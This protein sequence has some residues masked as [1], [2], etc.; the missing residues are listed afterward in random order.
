MTLAWSG[1][2]CANREKG[3]PL[4]TVLSCG[5]FW[6]QD[7]NK[8]PFQPLHAELRLLLQGYVKQLQ[9]SPRL[10]SYRRVH[11][12]CAYC[13]ALRCEDEPCVV[14]AL[15]LLTNDTIS[16]PHHVASSCAPDHIPLHLLAFTGK[17]ILSVYCCFISSS[18]YNHENSLKI[19]NL[20]I[21]GLTI[22]SS[23]ILYSFWSRD[24][25]LLVNIQWATNEII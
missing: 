18:S 2:S 22:T 5:S 21:A 7:K 4:S 17:P 1:P 3:P 11:I 8:F 14:L 25:S 10:S 23:P 16:R 15:K 9:E 20:F 19:F 24:F 12:H 6:P 13:Q